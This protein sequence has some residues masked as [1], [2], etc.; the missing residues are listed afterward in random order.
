MLNTIIT[1]VERQPERITTN[2]HHCSSIKTG[3][4]DARIHIKIQKI[5][6]RIRI[7][8]ISLLNYYSLTHSLLLAQL[9]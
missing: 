7:A 8:M 1:T 3:Q 9:V 2:N 6:A 4:R 5:A